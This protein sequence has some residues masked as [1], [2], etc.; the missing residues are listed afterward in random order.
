MET[1]LITGGTG[2]IGRKLSGMLVEKGYSV[3][4][5]SRE[6]KPQQAQSAIQFATWD[7]EK[8]YLD[9]DA[10]A[11][12][13]HIIHLAGAGVA[14]KRWTQKRK[15]E[16]ILSRTQSSGLLVKSLETVPNKVKTVISASAIGWYGPDKRGGAPFKEDLPAASDFLGDTCRQW[17]DS[18]SHV[19]ASGKRLVILR[20]GIVLANEGGALVE[21]KKPLKAGIATILGNGRQIVSWI[22]IDDICRMYLHMLQHSNVAGVF[23][24]VAPT[25]VSN[26]ELTIQLAKKVR[27]KAYISLHVPAFALKIALGEMSIEVLKSATVSAAKIRAAGFTFMYPSLEAA[28]QQLVAAQ[29]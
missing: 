24:A 27:G 3:I 15:Q 2:L 29:H 11:A 20:T 7:V 6:K 18:I 25:P 12:A 19:T 1:V 22:H 10:V 23:N 4:I 16:I 21:F 17:E 14:E 26:K 5:L 13:D 9:K 28:L 8:G